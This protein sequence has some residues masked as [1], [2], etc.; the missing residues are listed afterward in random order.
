VLYDDPPGAQAKAQERAR[1]LIATRSS[2]SREWWRFEDPTRL[3]CVLMTDRLALTVEEERTEPWAPATDWYPIRSRLVHNLEAARQLADG[4]LWGSLIISEEPLAQASDEHLERILAE[5][6]PH[7]SADELAELRDAYLGNLTWKAAWTAVGSR[8][9][10]SA[11]ER[12]S[13]A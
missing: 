2:W 13:R 4:H 1:E 12:D 11:P 3:E 8:P 5:G 10:S 6:A 9:C 7:C